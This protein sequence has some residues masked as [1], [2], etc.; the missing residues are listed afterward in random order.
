M[1]TSTAMKHGH[2]CPECG[3]DTKRDR[4]G[5]GFVAHKTQNDPYC[6]FERGEKD[7]P[8]PRH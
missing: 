1:K 6:D 5:R 4:I 2:T 7:A 8:A 3:D